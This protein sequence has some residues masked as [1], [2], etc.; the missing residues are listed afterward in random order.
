MSG[1]RVSMPATACPR[2]FAPPR[3]PTTSFRHLYRSPAHDARQLHHGG[4][5]RAD[6]RDSRGPGGGPGPAHRLSAGAREQRGQHHRHSPLLWRRAAAAGPP[7][8]GRRVG[9]HCPR[10]AHCSA[11]NHLPRPRHPVPAQV[12]EDLF[13]ATRAAQSNDYLDGLASRRPPISRAA[14]D[15]R[16]SAA[17]AAA[18][19]CN[20][21]RS[22]ASGGDAGQEAV[23]AAAAAEGDVWPTA[24]GEGE[25]LAAAAGAAPAAAA[26]DPTLG[27]SQATIFGRYLSPEALVCRHRL[28]KSEARRLYQA[29]QV[30]AGRRALLGRGRS[31]CPC[32]RGHALPWQRL[33][34][35]AAATGQPPAVHSCCLPLTLL[36]GRSTPSRWASTSCSRILCVC[37]RVFPTSVH[38]T[39]PRSPRSTRWASTRPRWS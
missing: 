38:R 12:W 19:A 34:L 1:A 6:R 28:S 22:G 20:A 11:I 14:Q 5:A 30:G 35:R 8:V 25:G 16:L 27:I 21:G 32:T 26:D 10:A 2:Q 4:H 33:L 17:Q 7:S 15:A 36:L 9:G 23:P 13:A 37:V 18:Q 3:L 31:K 24:A 39:S 29:L